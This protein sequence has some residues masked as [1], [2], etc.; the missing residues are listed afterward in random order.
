[1]AAKRTCFVHRL[2]GQRNHAAL[3]EIHFGNVGF[4][5]TKVEAAKVCGQVNCRPE[6]A[7]RQR[8]KASKGFSTRLETSNVIPTAFASYAQPI[9]AFRRDEGC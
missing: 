5:A 3:P 1:M 9:R 8:W 7:S 2:S 6:R 4:C